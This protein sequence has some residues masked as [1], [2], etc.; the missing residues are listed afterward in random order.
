MTET[1]YLK[2]LNTTS[3]ILFEDLMSVIEQ[4]Y[5]FTPSAF[6]NG[7][8]KNTANENQGSAKLL[9]FAKIHN[10]NKQQTLKCFGQYYNEVLETPNGTN[11]NNIRNFMKTGWAGI[12]FKNT[13]I[14]QKK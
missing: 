13:N 7:S 5:R 14:L 1:N 3:K 2:K 8:L 11:H 9:S 4:N 12:S 6:D 10:L